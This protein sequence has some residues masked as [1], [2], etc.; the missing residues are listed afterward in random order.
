[1]QC[2]Y[3]PYPVP[4]CRRSEPV[5]PGR[6]SWRLLL[7]L[8]QS[9][10]LPPPARPAGGFPLPRFAA[11]A[12]L[13]RRKAARRPREPPRHIHSSTFSPK[14]IIRMRNYFKKTAE[15]NF[16]AGAVALAPEAGP[17]RRVGRRASPPPAAAALRARDGPGLGGRGDNMGRGA[18]CSRAGQARRIRGDTRRVH[19]VTLGGQGDKK[20]TRRA[21]KRVGRAGVA[22]AANGAGGVPV[23][24]SWPGVSRRDRR[25]RWTSGTN[26]RNGRQ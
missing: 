25:Y 7:S 6:G 1:M 4:A 18:G 5:A 23:P 21:T 14:S 2:V 17:R 19:A 20:G 11:P 3:V 22:G 26:S 10:S 12:A 24:R 9:A 8:P 16:R 13:L 15:R